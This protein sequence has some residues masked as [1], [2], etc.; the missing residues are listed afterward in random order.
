MGT[1]LCLAVKIL[2][3]IKIDENEKKNT[4][5]AVLWH[6]CQAD[7]GDDEESAWL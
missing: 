1:L 3:K 6:T 7:D 4:H 2:Q 5:S